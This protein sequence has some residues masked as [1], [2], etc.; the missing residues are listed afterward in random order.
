MLPISLIILGGILLIAGIALL[1][2]SPKHTTDSLA[3]AISLVK[4]DGVLTLKEEK[5]IREIAEKEGKD[6][7]FEIAKIHQELQDSDEDS[8]TE[9]IDVNVKAGLD[10]EKFIIQKFDKNYFQIRNWAGDKYVEGRYADTTTQ[11]DIQLSLKLRGKA[12]PF[13]V[14][15]KWRSEPKGD[16]IRFANDGQLERY[17]AFAKRENYPVFIALGVGGKAASPDELYILPIEELTK[18]FLHKDRIGKYRKKLDTDFFF[19]Q[20]KGILR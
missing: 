17:K 20:E 5:L 6:G 8:E 18:P 4:A 19:D 12:Y 11:P 13:A 2:Q 10:F 16:F 7:D 14:E 1:L 3:Q 15:C 9:L